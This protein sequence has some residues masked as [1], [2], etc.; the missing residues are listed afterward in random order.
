MGVALA[1]ECSAKQLGQISRDF[2]QVVRLKLLMA[3]PHIPKHQRFAVR[4]YRKC[5]TQLA[6]A[7]IK[8]KEQGDPNFVPFF[9]KHW[10]FKS[11]KIIQVIRQSRWVT[12]KQYRCSRLSLNETGIRAFRA[13]VWMTD[14]QLPHF[15]IFKKD[16]NLTILRSSLAELQISSE[17]K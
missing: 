11:E 3:Y 9:R 8:N 1:C 13:S 5:L 2:V 7:T 6:F 14:L 12:G 17:S 4:W 16:V 10:T 15:D